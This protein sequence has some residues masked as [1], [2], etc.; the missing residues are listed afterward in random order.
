M[1]NLTDSTML[2]SFFTFFPFKNPEHYAWN[3]YPV[4]KNQD[5]SSIIS[6]PNPDLNL[7]DTLRFFAS[8]SENYSR[9]SFTSHHAQYTGFID[10]ISINN[11]YHYS[12]NMNDETATISI[13]NKEY[14]HDFWDCYGII[15]DYQVFILKPDNT[16]KDILK[17]YSSNKVYFPQNHPYRCLS[18]NIFKKTQD[19]LLKLHIYKTAYSASSKQRLSDDPSPIITKEFF[20]NLHGFTLFKYIENYYYPIRVSFDANDEKSIHSFIYISQYY[21]DIL[22]RAH[23]IELD[24][25]FFVLRPYVYCLAEAIIYNESVPFALSVGPTENKIL[26]YQIYD[27]I[28]QI[29]KTV[30]DH[31][32]SIPILSDEGSAL[33][34]FAKE[35]SLV[36]YFCYHHL[37]NKF[38]S[39]QLSGIVKGLLFSQTR[40]EFDELWMNQENR[41]K[42]LLKS[43]PELA[44]KFCKL[45]IT[46]YNSS[47]NTLSHPQFNQQSL[48]VRG[49][50]HVPTCTNHSESSHMHLNKSACDT[51]L[52]S[53]RLTLIFNYM[54]NRYAEFL[55]RK[56][57]KNYISIIKKR[58]SSIV[59]QTE[60]K[61][62]KNNY[63]NN[64]YGLELPCIHTVKD[65]EIP[66]FVPLQESTF[67]QKYIMTIN[68]AQWDFN[69]KI[70]LPNLNL[71]LE[72]EILLNKLGRPNKSFYKN[73]IKTY[74]TNYDGADYETI[75][76]F[77]EILFIYFS[78]K[79]YGTYIYNEE[80]SENFQKFVD[81][82]IFQKSR[83][84]RFFE[85]QAINIELREE[86]LALLKRKNYSDIDLDDNEQS[87][88]ETQDTNADFSFPNDED[89]DNDEDNGE[90]IEENG[91]KNE[92]NGDKNEE[93][94]DKNEENGDRNEENGDKNEENG[95]NIEEKEDKNEDSIFKIALKF[96]DIIHSINE[97]NISKENAK[98]YLQNAFNLFQKFNDEIKQ[99]GSIEEIFN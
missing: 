95:D 44:K 52:F 63:K 86:N 64:L 17:I 25:S 68:E 77:I 74:P 89:N 6:N 19:P 73:I 67:D 11:L 7:F 58:S 47:E 91:D 33:I 42:E 45:F 29:N 60:C 75:K 3:I 84:D 88:Q 40:D 43:N 4:P 65:F 53:K 24:T 32:I 41:I 18:H 5:F 94:G 36:Q 62:I 78:S 28:K 76:S 93:N 12:I 55:K 99:D 15:G 48:W 10:Y 50:A 96:Q 39:S 92:E 85:K 21:E 20:I 34:A 70:H 37:L 97:E 79:M 22:N 72:F 81:H 61:C 8:L 80:S 71:P 30:Y 26:Y 83:P 69:I 66:P 87:N 1:K 59:N 9:G 35:L 82:V 27:T 49:P 14:F 38:G 46:S 16:Y 98:H 23:C 13:R 56:N 57:L 51:K 31:M 2:N 90:N 54:N